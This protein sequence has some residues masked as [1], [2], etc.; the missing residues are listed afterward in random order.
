MDLFLRRGDRL[1]LGF[2]SILG[3]WALTLPALVSEPCV[4][5][6]SPPNRTATGSINL[7][8]PPGEKG[9]SWPGIT[10]TGFRAA[11]FLRLA[12]ETS[13]AMFLVTTDGTRN[14][15]KSSLTMAASPMDATSPFSV[16][17][18][19]EMLPGCDPTSR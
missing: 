7:S 10:R 6:R 11:I 5:M 4:G 12:T 3:V 2:P 19:T 18:M 17:A 1:F 16:S 15:N 14:S 8:Q 13:G 9:A